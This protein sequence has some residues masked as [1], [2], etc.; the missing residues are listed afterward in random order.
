MK[1]RCYK[2]RFFNKRQVPTKWYI[3][4]AEGM[5]LGRLASRIVPI[6]RGKHKPQFTPHEDLGDHV[7]VINAEKIRLTG[8]KWEQKE[9]QRYSG[10]PGGQKVMT[11]REIFQRDPRRL[12]ELAVKRMLPKTRLGRRQFHKLHVFVGPDHIHKAQK[13]EP[14]VWK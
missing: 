10:Y 12:I 13:P 9:Y 6:L 7:I 14:L 8:K 3:V 2:T 1:Q 4:D 11:A 5:V